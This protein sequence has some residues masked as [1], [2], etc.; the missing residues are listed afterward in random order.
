[1]RSIKLTIIGIVCMC[2]SLCAEQDYRE[3]TRHS[4]DETAVEYQENTVK[5]QPEVKAQAF[6]S[7]LPSH[8]LVLDLGCGPGRDAKYFVEQ[9]HRVVGVDISSQMIDLA[10]ASV[11]EAEFFVSDIESL[12]LSPESFDAI[13]ASASLLHVSKQAMPGALTAL[14]RALKPGGVFYLSMKKG[15]GEELKA[16]HRYGGVEKFWNYVDEA[17]LID[18]LEDQGFQI[19]AQDTHDKSTSYQTHPWISV[20]CKK[21]SIR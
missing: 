8:S 13:W 14:Y 12:D 18:L 21:A 20:I 9:G 10:R 15:E 3:V 17:E 11:P 5:L 1:M 7:Y 19:L 2:K 4:Y 6:L 16:D